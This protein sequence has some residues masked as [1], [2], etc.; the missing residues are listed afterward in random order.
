MESKKTHSIIDM[1]VLSILLKQPMNAY[2]LAQYVEQNQVTRLVKISTPAI[3]K[4]CKRLYEQQHLDGKLRRDGEAPEK[5]VYTVTEAG[6]ARFVELMQHFASSITPFY[7]EINSV[8][9]GLEGLDYKPGLEL[10]DTYM[11]Q[12]KTMQ[13]YLIPHSHE[14][15]A[16]ATFASRMIVKQYLMTVEVLVKWIEELREEYIQKHND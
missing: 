6:N 10:I 11:S 12:I 2:A 15:Q 9:Y 13:S 1:V 4:S 7:F 14:T 16:K 8:V 3:Y 5:M